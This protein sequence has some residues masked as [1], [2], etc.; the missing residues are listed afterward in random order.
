[1]FAFIRG[2]L[3]SA[4]PLWC[5]VDTG[6][7]GYKLA[8]AATQLEKLPPAGQEVLLHTSFIVRENSQMLYGFLGTHER[9]AFEVLLNVSG[10]GPKLALSIIGHLT[11]AQLQNAI[12][13][14]DLALLGKIPGVGKK[15][16]ERLVMEL[17]DKL[18]DLWPHTGPITTTTPLHS[19]VIADAISALINLGYSN[20]VAQKAVNKSHDALPTDSSLAALITHALKHVHN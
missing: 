8:I 13:G 3:I 11:P 14:N 15:T 9:D 7:V 6:P 5:V 12:I 16:A 1:M 18:S 10:I 2:T 20:A 4:T 17:K 19:P